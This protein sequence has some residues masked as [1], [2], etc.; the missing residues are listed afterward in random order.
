MIVVS[1]SNALQS[2]NGVNR[3]FVLPF[4][5]LGI[6]PI[7]QAL[8]SE[9][10]DGTTIDLLRWNAPVLAGAGAVTQAA[11]ALTIATST[12]LSNA[13][14]LSSIDK[15]QPIGGGFLGLGSPIQFE[16]APA[17][18]THRFFGKGTPNASFTAATPLADAYGWELDITGAL[19]CVT[20]AA[21]VRTIWGTKT[22]PTDGAPHILVVYERA[23]AVYFHFDNLEEPFAVGGYQQATTSSLPI[24]LH[25][26]NHTTGPAGAPTFK[27]YGVAVADYT[28]SYKILFDGQR[29][30]A[31][32]SQGKIINLAAVGIASETIIWTPAAGRKFRLLGY[33]LTSGTVG[34]NVTLRDN[35][36]GATI[37]TIPFGAA[38]AP[39]TS[40]PNFGNGILSAVAGNVLTA[41]GAATQT[42]SG[43]LFGCEE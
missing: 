40:P 13:G 14:A 43:Y 19:N 35:T 36:A 23:N 11:G 16:A 32:R 39:D 31:E 38:A 29:V 3:A 12:T 18:N 37:L 25:C 9:P 6:C 33:K 4:G 5:A 24:R 7:G 21:N 2:I 20:Y 30:Q 27:S 8:F 28:A 17:T 22:T 15:F 1:Q 42:L 26:I 34:G 41:Q 10:F